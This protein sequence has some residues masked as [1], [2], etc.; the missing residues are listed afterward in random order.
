MNK[1]FDRRK[2]I[3]SSALAGASLA[4]S[5]IGLSESILKPFTSENDKTKAKLLRV[6]M[7]GTGLRGRSLL[8]V[9]L[10]REDC[11]L[12]AIADPDPAAVEATNKLCQDHGKKIP[13]SYSNGNYDYQNLLNKEKLDTVI[14]ASPW[15]W[16]TQQAIEVMKKGIY[17]GLEVCGAFS[18]DEC[19][20]LVNTFEETGTHLFFLENVCYRRDVLAIL[21]MVREGMFGELIHLEGGY[22]HD[23]RE[24][25]FNN[26]KQPYGGGVE[27]G[28]KGMSEARWRTKNSLCR[29]GDLYPTH[30]TGPCMKWL[31]INRGNRF[32]HLVSMSSKSKGLHE[33]IVK[34]GGSDHPNAKLEWKLGDVVTTLI[35]TSR[36][37]KVLLSH[38]TNLPRPY[39]LGFRVQGTKG[40]WMDVNES[41]LLEGIT[42]PHE[43]TPAKDFLEKYDHPLWKK[44]EHKAIGAGHGGMDYFVVHAFVESAKRKQAAV[45]DVY[46]AATMMSITPL[47]EQ[48]ISFG[49]APVPFP[50]FTRG[51]WMNWKPDFGM[52]EDF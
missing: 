24:V 40:I 27:F 7:I 37:E 35:Q 32:T 45:I 23:L 10:K 4:A 33:Y 49:S 52:G 9:L 21:R 2:F 17:T 29:N 47:S 19:W 36:G 38:D 8:G 48:S 50:D 16:H 44:F 26:G 41:L 12:I 31:D 18:L 15:E 28:E 43:W 30:D 14:I 39:S 25:K 22:Q 34:N 11:E 6:G 5:S 20:R 1:L 46:D 51:K 3:K 42:K 13:V